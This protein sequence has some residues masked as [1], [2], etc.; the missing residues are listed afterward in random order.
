MFHRRQRERKLDDFF[1]AK[2]AQ[3]AH[4]EVVA[5]PAWWN[6]QPFLWLNPNIVLAHR[7]WYS[8]GMEDGQKTPRGHPD[9]DSYMKNQRVF[10]IPD[11]RLELFFW[12]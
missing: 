3:D 1:S 4:Q 7:N 9:F 8:E 5:S 11:R 2:K 12:S 10:G 6:N